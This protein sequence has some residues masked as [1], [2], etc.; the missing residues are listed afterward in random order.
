[1]TLSTCEI[2]ARQ[3]CRHGF[4]SLTPQ[5]IVGIDQRA[6][7]SEAADLKTLERRTSAAVFAEERRHR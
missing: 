5:A 7:R 1:M 6:E 3:P 2:Y 4:T